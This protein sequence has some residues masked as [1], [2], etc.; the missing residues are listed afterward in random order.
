MPRAGSNPRR[1]PAATRQSW[2][3]ARRTPPP[4]PS[5]GDKLGAAVRSK[6][7]Q[8]ASGLAL[9]ALTALGGAA[10]RALRKRQAA[11]KTNPT[12]DSGR[13]LTDPPPE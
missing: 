5:R 4:P 1:A 3:P 7:T 13:D 11:K 8:I 9:S 2:R 12:V 6:G 10:F